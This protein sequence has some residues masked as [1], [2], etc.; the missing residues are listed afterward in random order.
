MTK[1]TKS[2]AGTENAEQ[3]HVRI[4][5]TIRERISLLKYEPG[6]VLSEAELASEFAVSRTP[7]RKVLQRLHYE[8]LTEVRNGVG[9]IVT[10]IN[11][12]TLKE[13]YDLRMRL[14]E[15]MGELSPAVLTDEHS[16]A[17]EQQLEKVRALHGTHDYEG[18]ARLCNDLEEII[19]TMIGSEPLR[20]I[21]D[22]F[23]Y[24][25]S[26]IWFTF[27]PQLDWDEMVAFQEKE[28]ISLLDAVRRNDMKGVG[29]IR[30]I[31]LHGILNYVSGYLSREVD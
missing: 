18:Y 25:V 27:L 3:R 28:I 7:I 21:T 23:Y 14:A 1:L 19:L 20:E 16:A 26:R 6:T 22:L 17:L 24:R 5:K 15:L 13:I 4:Y 29:Q 30:R 12:K 2:G 9:T 8:G 31:Y 10:D 11:L